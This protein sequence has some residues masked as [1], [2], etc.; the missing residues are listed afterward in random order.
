MRERCDTPSTYFAVLASLLLAVTS[1]AKAEPDELILRCKGSVSSFMPTT[2][3]KDNELIGVHIKEGKI[4]VSGN[5]FLLGQ[6]IQLCPPGTLRIPSDTLFFDS[7]GCS[8]TAKTQ[9]RQYGTLNTILMKLDVTN[10]TDRIGVTG[11]F[12]CTKI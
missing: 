2:W 1:D 6:N 8:G 3:T 11:R 5:D 4:T 12:M 9:T 10:T 7:D